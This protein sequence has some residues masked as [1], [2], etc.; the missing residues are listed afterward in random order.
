MVMPLEVKGFD[1]FVVRV[2]RVPR[3]WDLTCLHTIKPGT[4]I[5]GVGFC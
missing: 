2:D 5:V 3:F 1:L 4:Q